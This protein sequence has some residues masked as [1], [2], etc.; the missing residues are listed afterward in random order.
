MNPVSAEDLWE[1]A[2]V[3]PVA[4]GE[5]N[6]GIFAHDPGYDLPEICG[7]INLLPSF[8]LTNLG[9]EPL[10]SASILLKWNGMNVETINWTGNIRQLRNVVE[11][12][13]IY[14]RDK[15]IITDEDIHQHVHASR[16]GQHRYEDL[17]NKHDTLEDLLRYMAAE[18]KKFKGV[19][20]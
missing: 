14:C 9:S 20:V 15:K 12:L 19:K 13:L 8:M 1:K 7:A 3:C 10:T 18:Y 16:G 11:R 6:A 4:F 17:F 2:Q 5:N